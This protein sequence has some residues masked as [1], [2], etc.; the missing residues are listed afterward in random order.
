V[1][2]K[3]VSSGKNITQEELGL[4][5]TKVKKVK[6]RNALIGCQCLIKDEVLHTRTRHIDIRCH[7]IRELVKDGTVAIESCTTEEMAADILTKLL[8]KSKFQGFRAARF[9]GY[10]ASV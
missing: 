2:W 9:L 1:G 5:F 3:I 10:A 8:T 4:R 7:K 6:Q